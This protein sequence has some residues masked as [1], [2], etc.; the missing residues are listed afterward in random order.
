MPMMERVV[1]LKRPTIKPWKTPWKNVGVLFLLNWV[2]N[3]CRKKNLILRTEIYSQ[4]VWIYENVT[5]KNFL[6]KVSVYLQ[7]V[8]T[9]VSLNNIKYL[10]IDTLE[11]QQLLDGP[12]PLK[13][14]Q[15][16]GGSRSGG[17]HQQHSERCLCPETL[18]SY[19]LQLKCFFIRRLSGW[20][21][22]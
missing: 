7:T 15:L 19:R 21:R 5:R 3:K 11:H 14:H 10:H 6:T 4:S 18:G 16:V 12:G 22:R 20:S 8:V 1:C 2:E 13:V 9:F 17:S